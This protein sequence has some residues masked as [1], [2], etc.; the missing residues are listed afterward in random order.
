M[1]EFDTGQYSINAGGY[2]LSI[3]ERPDSVRSATLPVYFM[4]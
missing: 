3:L 1:E 2:N 4:S